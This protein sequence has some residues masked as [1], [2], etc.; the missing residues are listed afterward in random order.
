MGADEIKGAQ[1]RAEG[2]DRVQPAPDMAALQSLKTPS[3][4]MQMLRDAA[5]REA[6]AAV[7]VF[8]AP[9]HGDQH[10]DEWAASLAKGRA[11]V[12]AEVEKSREVDQ[13][14]AAYIASKL[15][16]P[17]VPDA[18]TAGFRTGKAAA[19]SAPQPTEPTNSTDECWVNMRAAVIDA[20]AA[21]NLQIFSNVHGVSLVPIRKPEHTADERVAALMR[22]VDDFACAVRQEASEQEGD[23]GLSIQKKIEQSARALLGAAQ[24]DA[25]MLDWLD[26]KHIAMFRNDG[27]M[28]C[29][30][31]EARQIL[32]WAPSLREA[33]RAAM[34]AK[35]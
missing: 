33:I 25:A 31:S 10:R 17:S 30:N 4:A 27:G 20:L 12:A 8:A 11:I 6:Q 13:A 26:G 35:P 14:F 28:T 9:S 22:L 29:L 19:L 16:D 21:R 24:E 23:G 1:C 7:D 34:K 32:E 5:A 15:N 3:E 18:F 2:D